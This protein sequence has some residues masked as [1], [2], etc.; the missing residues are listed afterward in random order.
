MFERPSILFVENRWCYGDSMKTMS[1][2]TIAIALREKSKVLGCSPS[3]LAEM[4]G[5]KRG[6]MWF[7]FLRNGFALCGLRCKLFRGCLGVG[8][9]ELGKSDHL[10]SFLSRRKE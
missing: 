7:S 2:A 8:V 6:R 10:S 4:L 5:R 9:T 1:D 3:K